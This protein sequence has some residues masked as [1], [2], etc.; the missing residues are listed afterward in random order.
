MNYLVIGVNIILIYLIVNQ[1]ISWIY[2]K[3][4][5]EGCPANNSD[6][7][8]DRRRGAKR[9]EINSTIKDLKAEINPIVRKELSGDYQRFSNMTLLELINQYQEKGGTDTQED[10]LGNDNPKEFLM[11]YLI[12]TSDTEETEQCFDQIKLDECSSYFKCKPGY[13]F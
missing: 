6:V 13:S 4:G 3:E 11:Q 12:E 1:I 7:N 9:R 5:L 10:I 2:I 8:A